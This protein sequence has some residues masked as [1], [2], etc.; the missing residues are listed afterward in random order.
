MWVTLAL[1]LVGL[2]N[3]YS[4][5][6]TWEEGGGVSHLFWLQCLWVGIGLLA[7]IVFIAIDYRFLERLCWVIYFITLF[8]LLATLL[9]G[10]EIS[11]HKS[12]LMLG[13][14]SFQPS[15]FA[16][17]SL[18]FILAKYFGDRPLP[19]GYGIY[20][21]LKPLGLAM[22]P[23][24]LILLG[25]DLGSALFFPLIFGSIAW[26][27]QIR[28]KT[29]AIFFV[30]IA[31]TA[32][33][34]YNYALSPYQKARV[35]TFINPTEDVRGTGYHLR[36]SKIAVGSGQFFGKG[37]LKGKINKLRYLPEKHTDFIFPVLAEEWGFFG[38]MIA[39]GLF[40]AFLFWA[41]QIAIKA[42]ERFGAF[43]GFGIAAL[44]F[45]QVVINL[46]G[47]L[48]IMPLT[49]VTLPFLSYGGSSL[50]VML[51]CVGCLFNINMRRFMF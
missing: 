11:G 18:I 32:I 5:L 9:F 14:L 47:V 22:V 44:V 27:A 49:G 6:N 35:L 1:L 3:L 19:E 40:G 28:R 34:G 29:L 36:Q 2:L 51:V 25:K 39:V 7:L 43:L 33:L 37:Y 30:L 16:K 17:L 24:C 13:S 8:L 26:S 42:R 21:L 50:L 46:G 45:W 20:Q 12:W 15:E 41:I 4:A 31:T 48:G 10:R 38:S 23:C